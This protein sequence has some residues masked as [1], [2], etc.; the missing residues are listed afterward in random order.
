[1][2]VMVFV[3]AWFCATPR[4]GAD[5]GVVRDGVAGGLLVEI[6]AQTAVVRPLARLVVVQVVGLHLRV[7]R[8]IR[9]RIDPR[10]VSQDLNGVV[11]VVVVD[12]V[13]RHRVDGAGPAV[14]DRDGGVVRVRDLVVFDVD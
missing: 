1:M 13:G 6:D 10:S 4:R 11:N 5:Q 7:R 12:L 3:P 9:E 2:S 8:L 14:A